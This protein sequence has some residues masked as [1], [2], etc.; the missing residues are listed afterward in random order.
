MF[1]MLPFGREGEDEKETAIDDTTA[2]LTGTTRW[3]LGHLV[4]GCNHKFH[5][6]STFFIASHTAF[7]KQD[8]QRYSL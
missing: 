5:F 8:R 2:P 6:C 3:R 4:L 1:R 7:K